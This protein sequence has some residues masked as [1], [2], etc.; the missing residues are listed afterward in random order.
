MRALVHAAVVLAVV[1]LAGARVAH[2]EEK[3]PNPPLPV[4]PP[5]DPPVNAPAPPVPTPPDAGEEPVDPFA[6]DRPLDPFATPDGSAPS[7]QP[8]PGA[9]GTQPKPQP[10]PKTVAPDKKT[11]GI[12]A[13]ACWGSTTGC[14]LGGC[15]PAVGTGVG[16]AI[17]LTF[18]NAGLAQGGGAAAACLSTVGLGGGIALGVPGV[19]LLGP[20]ASLGAFAGGLVGAALEERPPVLVVLGGLPGLAVGLVGSLTAIWGLVVLFNTSGDYLVPAT[21]LGASTALALAAGPITVAGMSIADGLGGP[22]LPGRD[23]APSD[24]GKGDATDASS[25]M[26]F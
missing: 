4:D 26:A 9:P 10:K 6:G 7:A 22:T 8:S 24:E 16:A 15:A 17:F 19:V 5:V 1:A 20:C 14:A 21:L 3:A 18:V 2:A 12:E 23:E 25:A 11:G 13:G